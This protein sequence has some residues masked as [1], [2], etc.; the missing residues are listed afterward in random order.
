MSTDTAGDELLRSDILKYVPKLSASSPVKRWALARLAD[1][2]GGGIPELL[3]IIDYSDGLTWFEKIVVCRVVAVVRFA[4]FETASVATAL[5]RMKD[6][7]APDVS[8]KQVGICILLPFLP[9]VLAFMVGVHWMHVA[10]EETTS[11]APIGLPLI[12]VLCSFFALT[13]CW[14][15]AFVTLACVR[16]YRKQC[17]RDAVKL[18]LSKL[19]A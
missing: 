9:G 15:A 12:P 10:F 13:V 17:I 2:P 14:V 4:S 3:S 1:E 6:T 11:D 8:R 16:C 19:S 5:R 18:T 7:D